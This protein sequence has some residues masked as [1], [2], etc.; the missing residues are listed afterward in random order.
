MGLREGEE[1]DGEAR[2]GGWGRRDNEAGNQCKGNKK[3]PPTVYTA[4][5]YCQCI[6]IHKVPGPNKCTNPS[7]VADSGHYTIEKELAQD[8]VLHV[9][10]CISTQL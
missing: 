3:N 10:V 8:Y 9:V 1:E 7:C 6:V 5:I 2:R 4:V